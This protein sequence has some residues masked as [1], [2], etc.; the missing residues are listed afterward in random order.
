MWNSNFS[1]AIR[2]SILCYCTNT[3]SKLDGKNKSKTWKILQPLQNLHKEF[4][5]DIKS[6]SLHSCIDYITWNVKKVKIT[7]L[8]IWG[9]ENFDLFDLLDINYNDPTL[10]IVTIKQH[11]NKEITQYDCNIAI[12]ITL[13]C[14]HRGTIN[15]FQMENLLLIGQLA[16]HGNQMTEER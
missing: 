5:E 6:N 2:K 9:F 12:S 11:K 1:K 4:F 16:H 13:L 7:S 3:L 10:K 15:T 8:W 14:F